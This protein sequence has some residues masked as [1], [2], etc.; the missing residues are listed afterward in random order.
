MKNAATSIRI[1][2]PCYQGK[3]IIFKNTVN[4]T[5]KTQLPILTFHSFGIDGMACI[6]RAICELSEAPIGHNDLLGN[7]L[8]LLLT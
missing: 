5:S 8:S 7:T 4:V 3:N 1:W 6:Q 2:S